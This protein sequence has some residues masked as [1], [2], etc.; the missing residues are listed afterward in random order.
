MGGFLS[1][2][3][4]G[5]GLEQG[6]IDRDHYCIER[7]SGL[8]VVHVSPLQGPWIRQGLCRHFDFSPHWRPEKAGVI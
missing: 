4:L 3:N 7:G 1:P 5:G 2:A 8:S 6:S